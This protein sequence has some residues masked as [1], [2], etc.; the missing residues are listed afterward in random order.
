MF[1]ADVKVYSVPES[2]AEN[3]SVWLENI[4]QSRVGERGG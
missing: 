3:S 2:R 4:E 1:Q